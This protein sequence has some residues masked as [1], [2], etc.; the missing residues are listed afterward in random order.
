MA[1]NIGK[2]ILSLYKT[3]KGKRTAS[4]CQLSEVV[5][6]ACFVVTTKV[7]QSTD[8]VGQEKALQRSEDCPS[9]VCFCCYVYHI[10]AHD[11]QTPMSSHGGSCILKGSREVKAVH[12]DD[13]SRK[14]PTLSGAPSPCTM[15]N[16]NSKAWP[17]G[18]S[19]QTLWLT[20][21]NEKSP[22]SPL[23]TMIWIA[24]R[25]LKALAQL[26]LQWLGG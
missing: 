16:V 1:W 15:L 12:A 4:S 25:L 13:S 18:T 6:A 14:F 24:E 11:A 19:E 26:L 10:I 3:C 9:Q 7:P 2:H 23:P 21:L 8:D 17:G 5:E 22:L 20:Q